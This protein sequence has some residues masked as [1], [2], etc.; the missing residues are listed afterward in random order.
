M[1]T[2]KGILFYSPE[3]HEGNRLYRNLH[4]TLNALALLI[5]SAGLGVVSLFFAKGRYPKD[6]FFNY[7]DK[8]LLIFLNLLPVLLIALL[9]FFI[10]NRVWIAILG[11]GVVVIVPTIINHIKLVLRNDPILATDIRYIS[12]A[13]NISSGYNIMINRHMMFT[14]GFI[15][16]ATVLSVFLLRARIRR[17]R[18]RIICLAVTCLVSCLCYLTLYRSDTIYTKTQ[19]LDDSMSYWSDSDQYVCRG[20]LYPLLYST[21]ELSDGKPDGYNANESAAY[22]ASFD[23]GDLADGQKINVIG[24]MLEAFNDLSKFGVLDLTDDPYAFLHELQAESAYGELVTNIFAGGTI[25]TERCFLTGS[26]QLI[27]YRAP[28]YS[29]ARWFDSQGYRTEF[30]HTGFDWFYNRRN[31]AEYMGFGEA[32]FFEDRYNMPDGWGAMHD[33]E[34]MPDLVTLLEESAAAGEPYFNFS[35]TY[36]N[37]GPYSD[38]ELER[39]KTYVA[40]GS[41]SEQAWYILNN[42]LAGI[43]ETNESLRALV[44]SL[45]GLDEPVVLVFFGDHNPWLGD[46][47]W[48]YEELGISFDGDDGF[49]NYYCTPW[50]IWA[51]DAAR[52]ILGE[53]Y[54]TGYKGSFSP[55]FLSAELFDLLGWQGSAQINALRDLRGYADVV[56]IT[57][58]VRED[59]VLTTA[60]SDETAEKIAEYKKL[61]Y[62]LRKDALD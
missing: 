30:C 56:H 33:D 37:H 28:V 60:P 58:M 51:N 55:C 32:Y 23:S 43:A 47:A 53:S 5:W 42:Y 44:N 52:G 31:V 11:S 1:K 17:G 41:V 16:L 4:W 15:I 19:N 46:A 54:T 25:D 12:E 18:A 38:S 20:F 7:F 29:L 2:L 14:A 35:V 49:Y 24:I 48:V 21:K 57:G 59:G 50:V 22:Y 3:K 26:T 34:F 40:E 27:E 8:P 13:A 62:Y 10:G 6:I 45:R 36:Q 61:E 39:E 9:I